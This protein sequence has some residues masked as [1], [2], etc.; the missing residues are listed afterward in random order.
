MTQIIDL[1]IPLKEVSQDFK[2]SINGVNI[3]HPSTTFGGSLTRRGQN[4]DSITL[5]FPR[6]K[7]RT[8]FRILVNKCNISGIMPVF[9][10]ACSLQC[11]VIL[12]ILDEEKLKISIVCDNKKTFDLLDEVYHRLFG[13]SPSVK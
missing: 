13:Q 10:L 8:K 4:S 9:N 2:T 3:I 5:N 1:V 7:F 11:C 6:L 12:I